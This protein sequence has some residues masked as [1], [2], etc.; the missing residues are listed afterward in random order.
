MET[1]RKLKT[2]GIMTLILLPLLFGFPQLV[3]QVKADQGS[4]KVYILKLDDVGAWWVDDHLKGT[5]F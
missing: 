1:M 4:V 5:R 3:P 2:L